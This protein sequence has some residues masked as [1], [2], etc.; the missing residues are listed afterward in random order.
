[1]AIAKEHGLETT[2]VMSVVKLR[3]ADID[4]IPTW[5]FTVVMKKYIDRSENEVAR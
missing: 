5:S 3:E 2:K 1:V 4:A